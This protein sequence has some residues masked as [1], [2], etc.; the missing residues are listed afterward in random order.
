[1]GCSQ[2]PQLEPCCVLLT[3]RGAWQPQNYF[4]QA[5]WHAALLLAL[6]G[7]LL[8][9]DGG[10]PLAPPAPTS[11]GILPLPTVKHC[12]GGRKICRRVLGDIG[13]EGWLLLAKRP[14]GNSSG[15]GGCW[16]GVLGEPTRQVPVGKGWR[17]EVMPGCWG[18]WG[19]GTW[20]GGDRGFVLKLGAGKRRAGGGQWDGVLLPFRVIASSSALT[21]SAVDVTFSFSDRGKEPCPYPYPYPYSFPYPIFPTLFSLFPATFPC[22]DCCWGSYIFLPQTGL[23]LLLNQSGDTE[24]FL[25][26]LYIPVYLPLPWQ[27]WRMVSLVGVAASCPE[28]PSAR[29]RTDNGYVEMLPNGS[30]HLKFVGRPKKSKPPISPYFRSR[31]EEARGEAA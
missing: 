29:N 27:E 25:G 19:G 9:G 20:Q 11:P 22:P 4:S 23:V 17:G 6:Q 18:L 7:G 31:Q 3:L 30:F 26:P 13:Q 16:E 1:M 15:K 10:L 8:G 5:A 14:L 12:G 28:Q 21:K 2:S 24:A